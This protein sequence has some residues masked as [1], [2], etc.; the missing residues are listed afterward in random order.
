MF[1]KAAD[2]SDAESKVG[3]RLIGG[4]PLWESQHVRT[5]ESIGQDLVGHKIQGKHP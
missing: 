1:D 4:V 2:C 5:N 3:L